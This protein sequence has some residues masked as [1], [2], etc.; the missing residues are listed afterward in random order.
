LREPRFKYNHRNGVYYHKFGIKNHAFLLNNEVDIFLIRLA[1][2]RILGDA[3]PLVRR[4]GP[5]ILE[6]E[7]YERATATFINTTGQ[8][9]DGHMDYLGSLGCGCDYLM[10]QDG[11]IIEKERLVCLS[12]GLVKKGL[13]LINISEIQSFEMKQDM[14]LNV[15]ITVIDDN[16]PDAIQRNAGY[17][18]SINNIIYD[19][20]PVKIEN[21]YPESIRDL[22]KENITIGFSDTSRQEG[23]KFNVIRTTGESLEATMVY[24]GGI[25]RKEAERVF[26]DIQSL[27]EIRSK[28]K[29][30]VLVY[31]R[32]G[33]N[34][35]S[36]SDVQAGIIGH[37]EEEDGPTIINTQK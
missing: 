17:I 5:E 27:F 22:R 7:S 33:A 25:S 36:I 14:E 11:C 16:R 37:T 20:I 8:V 31:Y 15:R 3:Q 28:F 24:V 23:Y 9:P 26:D 10:H 34:Y 19:I 29:R 4:D 13:P 18:N 30:R 6:V 21:H 1:P 2:V 32:H 12:S 35:L